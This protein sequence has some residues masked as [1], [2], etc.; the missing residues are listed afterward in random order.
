MCR[1]FITAGKLSRLRKIIE[2]VYNE[3][4]KIR[5]FEEID[6]DEE[7]LEEEIDE[8]L[9]DERKYKRDYE[10]ILT[11][12][13]PVIS[14]DAGEKFITK[15][16]WGIRFSPEKK[17]P[18]IFNSRDDTI[19]AK[20]F[21]KNTFDKNRILIPMFGFYEWQDIGQKRKLKTKITL[22]GRKIFL[23]PGLYRKNKESINEF[24]LITTSP[25]TFMKKIHTR[26]PVILDDKNVFNYFTDS[27]DENLE[28]LKPIKAEMEMEE[29]PTP[30]QRT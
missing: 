15:M 17:S 3:D 25:N 16:K 5:L 4:L 13:I 28:K 10:A 23:V 30:E 14:Y 7:D 1:Q 12:D 11:H 8:E 18:L 24:T 26:M 21:W 20:P 6:K 22:T 2:E 27:A 19:A 29:L 9:D